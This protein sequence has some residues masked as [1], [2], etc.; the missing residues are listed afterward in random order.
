LPELNIELSAFGCWLCLK[1]EFESTKSKNMTTQLAEPDCAVETSAAPT[2][3]AA[4]S[5]PDPFQQRIE[6]ALEGIAEFQ[7]EIRRIQKR[8]SEG[9]LIPGAELLRLYSEKRENMPR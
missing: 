3:T 5:D 1:T 2:Q 7:E 9:K 8:A 4:H 6:N